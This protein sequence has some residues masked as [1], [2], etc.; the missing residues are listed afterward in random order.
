M[1]PRLLAAT[2]LCSAAAFAFAAPGY[3][4]DGLAY[5]WSGY[6][7]GGA[8]GYA[9]GSPNTR[10]E[11]QGDPDDYTIDFDGYFLNFLDETAP[12]D[13]WPNSFD[14]GNTAWL[15]TVTG[16]VNFQSGS[17]VFGVEG[18]ASLLFG[19]PDWYWTN[20]EILETEPD[21]LT[22]I[23]V[24]GGL[25]SL[26]TIRPRVGVA[27][28]R[29]L[30]FGTGGLALGHASLST[31][32]SAIQDN[33][34]GAAWSGEESAWKAG[35]VIG[36]GAEYAFTDRMSLKLEGLYYDVGSITA[37]AE[38]SGY[39]QGGSTPQTTQPYSVTTD[40]SGWLIRAG[41]NIGF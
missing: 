25:D 16:G 28:D 4:Q 32:A 24:S 40:L 35:F 26:F 30:L 41:V 15:A 13:P 23:K 20:E 33:G 37:K 10:L 9:G 31:Q 29:L 5:D 6:Y 17:L 18:D 8:I 36:G 38:G 22:E 2:A 19:A 14:L 1:R 11:P 27:I 39:S 34:K 3:A 21:R 7:I 12:Y